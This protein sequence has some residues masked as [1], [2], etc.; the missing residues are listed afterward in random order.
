MSKIDNTIFSIT[1][2]TRIKTALNYKKKEELHQKE[3]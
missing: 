2:I 1:F 3:L